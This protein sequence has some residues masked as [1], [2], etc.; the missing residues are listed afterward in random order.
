ML[1][2]KNLSKI[3]I[4]K[5]YFKI[6]IISFKILEN[7][8]FLKNNGSIIKKK[9]VFPLGYEGIEFIIKIHFISQGHFMQ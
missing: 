1:H 5:L 7:D 2:A 4:T 9:C 6:L 3:F 8:L